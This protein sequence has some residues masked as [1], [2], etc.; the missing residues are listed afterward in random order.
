[1]A[2]LYKMCTSC[3]L[4]THTRPGKRRKGGFLRLLRPDAPALVVVINQSIPPTHTTHTHT[5]C[6]AHTRACMHA[7]SFF[8]ESSDVGHGRGVAKGGVYAF[9]SG[10]YFGMKSPRFHIEIIV[11]RLFSSYFPLS[12]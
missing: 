9:P 8:P 4:H 3:F 1:M 10:G 6:H 12:A 11:C 7:L 5:L 2:K